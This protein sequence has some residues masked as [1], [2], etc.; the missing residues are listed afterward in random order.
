MGGRGFANSF[1]ILANLKRSVSSPLFF[2]PPILRGAL[3]LSFDS[4]SEQ[5]GLNWRGGARFFGGVG[6]LG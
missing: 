1:G 5:G 4:I 3:I 6:G 2:H